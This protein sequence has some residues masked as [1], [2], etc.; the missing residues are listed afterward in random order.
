MNNVFAVIFVR[1]QLFQYSGYLVHVQKSDF[2]VFYVIFSNP[3][4]LPDWIFTKI[5]K[6]HWYCIKK[7]I[8]K[9]DKNGKVFFGKTYVIPKFCQS[10][11]NEQHFLLQMFS[12]VS[13]RAREYLRWSQ[14]RR[15]F[16]HFDT[17]LL[18]KG[19]LTDRN[20]ILECIKDERIIIHIHF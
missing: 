4:L 8:F 15:P 6:N 3:Y 2:I 20:H 11:R 9:D 16:Q 1:E 19:L 17:F 14:T 12:F 7:V 13:F 18:K 10:I 5:Q